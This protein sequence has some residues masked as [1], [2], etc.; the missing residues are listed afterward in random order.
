D[1]LASASDPSD[2]K[3][4]DEKGSNCAPMTHV[5]GKA[6]SYEFPADLKA[7]SNHA[8]CAVYGNGADRKT[9]CQLFS[10]QYPFFQYQPDE[11]GV[12]PAPYYVPSNKEGPV[13]FGVL[14]PALVGYIGQ[15]NDV[16]VN[17]EAR[18]DTSAQITD[19]IE[20]LRQ[21]LDLC[22]SDTHCKDRR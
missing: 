3:L 12:T 4:P 18:F 10:V 5:D 11:P 14:D 16:W 22:D 9:Q 19:P 15:L 2:F 8:L 6:E 7:G 13:V 1:C 21:V 20:A 17:S